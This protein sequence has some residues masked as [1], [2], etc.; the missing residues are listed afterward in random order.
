[1]TANRLHGRAPTRA[2]FDAMTPR[3]Q[4]YCCYM[5]ACWPGSK[6]PKRCPYKPGSMEYV[7]F[8]EG[9]QHAVIVAQDSE[10]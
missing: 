2:E 3:Q 6:I 5:F 10:E 8:R 7:E 1:M 4:G 9:E